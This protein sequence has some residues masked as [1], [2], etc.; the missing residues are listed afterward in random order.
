MVV[1][2]GRGLTRRTAL[3]A[4]ALTLAGAGRTE[5]AGLLQA[6]GNA[7]TWNGARV[8]LRGVAV[9]DP[10]LGRADRPVTDYRV[11]ATSWRCNAVRLSVHPTAWRHSQADA[12]RL[13]ERDAAAALSRRMW[14]II[15][16]HTIGWPDGYYQ[17]PDPSWGSPPD[18]YDSSLELARSFW[19]AM[20]ERWR[21]DGRVA[22]EL[23][24]E[25][26]FDPDAWDAAPGATWPDLRAR[27]QDLI[28]TVR[29]RGAPNLVL[30]GGDRWAYD[31]RGVRASPVADANVGYTWHVYAGHDG[32]DP[33][34]W[35]GKLD[36]VDRAFPVVVTEW[37][38]CRA[39]EGAHFQGSPETFGRVF[40]RRFLAGRGL[41]YTAWVWH[42]GWGP[43]MLEGDW[44]TPNEFG[45]F[46]KADLA[47]GGTPRP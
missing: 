24:N 20:A 40:L 42:P 9:G 21:G 5:A 12:L 35:A 16:W 26:V 1:L 27:Y 33:A 38:F 45:R 30:L 10:L 46:V 44:R 39:C 19:T 18:L 41:S 28:A 32:N 29:A 6:R 8:R 2:G 14:V 25:P 36:E 11:L 34:L 23:W 7:L 31:L 3:G 22:F 37:G 4:A 13:L 47:R 43:P 17:R 15:D